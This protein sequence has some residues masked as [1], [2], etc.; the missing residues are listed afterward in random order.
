[1]LEAVMEESSHSLTIHHV[2]KRMA[3]PKNIMACIWRFLIPCVGIQNEFLV[4]HCKDL[5]EHLANLAWPLVYI[6]IKAVDGEVVIRDIEHHD[7]AAERDS[8]MSSLMADEEF[9]LQVERRLHGPQRVE[10]QI[11]ESHSSSALRTVPTEFQT[12]CD[13]EWMENESEAS[14]DE[15]VWTN[16]AGMQFRDS[17]ERIFIVKFSRSVNTLFLRGSTQDESWSQ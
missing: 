14:F 9:A 16:Q 7:P 1:L 12:A 2:I 4:A 11:S 15:D 5:I 6:A 3:L 8:S 10:Q 13:L 17:F